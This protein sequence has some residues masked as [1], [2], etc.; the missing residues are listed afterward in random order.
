MLRPCGVTLS[1]AHFLAGT[2]VYP[3]SPIFVQLSHLSQFFLKLLQKINR[4]SGGY[5]K[6][7]PKLCICNNDLRKHGNLIPVLIN[8]IPLRSI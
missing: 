5:S 3:L 2:E 6:V 8:K 4:N 1:V 7:H